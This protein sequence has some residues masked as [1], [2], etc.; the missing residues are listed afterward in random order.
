[1]RAW[2]IGLV[3]IVVALAIPIIVFALDAPLFR[4]FRSKPGNEVAEHDE[5]DQPDLGELQRRL[6]RLEDDVDEL[7]RAVRELREDTQ[8]LE[9]M[10]E[11]ASGETPSAG[12]GRT[13][14]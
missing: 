2:T 7:I 8:Y 1:M 14:S 12:S 11:Q 13:D 5:A 10:I 9:S 6:E 4:R 3:V